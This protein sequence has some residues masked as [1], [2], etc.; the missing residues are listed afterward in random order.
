MQETQD[1]LSFEEAVARLEQIVGAMETGN[2]PLDECLR[3][4]EQAVTLSRYCAGKLDAAEKQ[5]SVLTADGTAQPIDEGVWAV[6]GG[7]TVR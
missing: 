6:E 1:Q 5:I 4:F 2:L 7:R 3:Q